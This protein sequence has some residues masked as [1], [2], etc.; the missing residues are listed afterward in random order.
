MRTDHGTGNLTLRADSNAVDNGGSIA[1]CGTVDWSKSTGIVSALYDMNGSY[2]PGTLLGNAAWTAAVYS[3][4]VTQITAY[5][6][7]NTVAD[8]QNVANNLA[9]NYALGTDIGTGNIRFHTLA[10]ATPFTGQFDGMWHTVSV[11]PDAGGMFGDIGATG[12]VR[13]VNVNANTGVGFGYGANG[14]GILANANDGTIANAFVSGSNTDTLGEQGVSSLA[15]LV[16]TNRGLIARSGSSASVNASNAAGLVLDN[17]GTIVESYFTGSV[18]GMFL[19]GVAGGLVLSNEGTIAQSFVSGAARSAGTP[20]GVPG[21]AGAI[22]VNCNGVSTDV[23]WNA[24]TTGTSWSGS[25]LPA[26]NGLT[27]AQMSDPASFA[28]WDFSANGAWAM[29]AGATYPV[30][31][32]QVAGH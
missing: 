11:G 20:P 27:T 6:L 2:S 4:L 14:A 13:D 30:L 3:G 10:S 17:Q 8:L 9:G 25:K 23:Y 32:W 1:S 5:Q 18:Y 7:V 22:C 16:G 31:A 28:G 26:S 29:P 24:Q 15:G 12:V 19:T 21:Q